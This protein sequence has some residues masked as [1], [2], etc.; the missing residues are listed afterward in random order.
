MLRI[1]LFVFAVLQVSLVTLFL[2]STISCFVLSAI[3]LGS[4][5]LE[6][7]RGLPVRRGYRSG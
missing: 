3:F 5:A 4:N 2:R 1:S 6:K 7:L